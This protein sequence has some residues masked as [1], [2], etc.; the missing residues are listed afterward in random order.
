MSYA[1]VINGEFTV[2]SHS[3][4]VLLRKRKSVT[5]KIIQLYDDIE[6]VSSAFFTSLIPPSI[7][8]S[9][10]GDLLKLKFSGDIDLYSDANTGQ[11][12]YVQC[13]AESNIKWFWKYG[14]GQPNDKIDGSAVIL[15]KDYKKYIDKE[16]S[17]KI[18]MKVHVSLSNKPQKPFYRIG[19]G[20][21]Y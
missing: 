17:M 14:L 11:E 10:G 8:K 20:E 2:S 7:L 9:L 6:E 13:N 16:E 1:M 5:D 3:G 19:Y 21:E 15:C 4:K 18:S 12:V